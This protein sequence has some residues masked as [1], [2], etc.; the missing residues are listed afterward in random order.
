MTVGQ[1]ITEGLLVHEPQLSR[2]ERD[3]ARHRRR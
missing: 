2:K 1:I 3:E